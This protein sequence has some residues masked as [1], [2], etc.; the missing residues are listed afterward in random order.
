MILAQSFDTASIRAC[1]L[2]PMSH[3]AKYA[4]L[5]TTASGFELDFVHSTSELAP[6]CPC[7]VPNSV[8]NT[9]GPIEPEVLDPTTFELDPRRFVGLFGTSVPMLL[10]A[11]SRPPA[12][13]A[14][15][16]EVVAAEVDLLSSP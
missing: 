13:L 8:P 7:H 12:V 9:V 5:E 1:E 4:S 11:G 16:L 3:V 10:A 2:D 15:G 14:A 6:C